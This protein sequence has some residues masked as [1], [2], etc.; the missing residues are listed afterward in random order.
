MD[1]ALM[2][3]AAVSLTVWLLLTFARGGYWQCK[4][5]FV[6]ADEVSPS[7]AE[8]GTAE[9]PRIAVVVP[10]RDEVEVVERSIS[11]LLSQ[12][13]PGEFGLI[14]VDDQSEDGTGAAAEACAVKLPNARGRL[15]VVRASERPAGWAPKVWAMEQGLSRAF[16]LEPDYVWFCDADIEHNPNV[17]RALVTKAERERLDQVSTMVQLAAESFS[18]KLLIPAFVLFFAKLYPFAWVNDRSVPD[19]AAAGGSLLARTDALRAAGAFESLRG[20]LIDDCA[21]AVRLSDVGRVRER[22][23]WLGTTTDSRCVRGYGGLSGVWRMVVRSAYVQLHYSWW[24]L[25]AT[26]LGM[27]LIYIAP[28]L[29]VV[30]SPFHA[31]G[32][33]L[34]FAS[35]AWILMTATSVPIFRR[36]GLPPVFALAIPVAGA[37]Y[38]A[39]TVDSARRHVQGLG[40]EW[41]GRDLREA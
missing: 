24:R 27:A 5:R 11:S 10:A 7:P 28:V 16:A 19:A 14:C 23:I 4:E 6:A 35:F 21:L 1:T 39:M 18:E 25:A 29:I 9:W 30:S 22:G 36:Y 37:L 2:L 34:L 17:L 38:T 33:A 41:K 3:V 31:N 8:T 26:V 20:A 32:Y 15:Q 13:Y 12:D 40:S